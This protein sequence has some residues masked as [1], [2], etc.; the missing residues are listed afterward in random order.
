MDLDFIPK[1]I[2]NLPERTDRLRSI[3]SELKWLFF[4]ESYTLVDGVRSTKAKDGIAMSHLSCIKSASEMFAPYCIII[5]DDC[6][7]QAKEKTREYVYKALENLPDDWDLLLAGVYESKRSQPF[8]EYW[9]KTNEFCGLHFYIV[10]NTAYE[11]I[12]SFDSDSHIDRWMARDSGLNCYVSKKFFA[13]QLNGF[14]DNV[15]KDVDYSDKL[16]RFELL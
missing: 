5:E 4:D 12:L 13:T 15:K 6:V 7:F 3:N 16:K 14:S 1:Y 8:N 9:F 11:K 2:I 10:K